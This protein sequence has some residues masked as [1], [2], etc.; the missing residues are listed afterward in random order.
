MKSPR[1]RSEAL[2]VSD[3]ENKTCSGWFV[4]FACVYFAQLRLRS[5]NDPNF[6]IFHF[7]N[8]TS[9]VWDTK[10]DANLSEK[11][12]ELAQTASSHRN[13][14]VRSGSLLLPRSKH[15]VYRVFSVLICGICH[16]LTFVDL[17]K[18]S[19]YAQTFIMVQLR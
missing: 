15:G 12:I 18:G 9:I 17:N 2:P 6:A 16:G 5:A 8:V 4:C 13:D 7:R 10:F 3:V 19:N 1:G 11:L 14:T